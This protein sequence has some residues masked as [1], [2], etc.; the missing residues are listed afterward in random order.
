MEGFHEKLVKC[1][2]FLQCLLVFSVVSSV[3]RDALSHYIYQLPTVS[4]RTST[5]G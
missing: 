5:V 3:C 2:I 1:R 4:M